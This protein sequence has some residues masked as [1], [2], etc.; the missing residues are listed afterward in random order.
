MQGPRLRLQSKS[1]R[2]HALPMQI[3]HSEPRD[4]EAIRALY[5]QPSV[6]ANTLQLPFPSAE[7]WQQRL[8]CL[9]THFHSLVADVD[10]RVLGQIGIERFESP[11]RAHAANIGLAVDESARGRGVGHALMSGAIELCFGWL[12]VRRIE[13]EVYTDNR[14]AQALF[15]RHGFEREG[16]SLG[17]A[18]RAGRYADVYLMA[19]RAP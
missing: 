7:L 14:A 4:I 17:Y 12:G 2:T 10:G 16:T 3:R 9:H 6:Y 19:L 11:R 1:G 15:L 18:F 5:A 8:G 13:L